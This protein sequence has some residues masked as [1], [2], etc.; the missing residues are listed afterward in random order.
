L[1][2][3]ALQ[4]IVGINDAKH[5][6]NVQ[7]FDFDGRRYLT[8]QLIEH[9][10]PRP[11]AL[12]VHS[13]SGFRDAVNTLLKDPAPYLIHIIDYSQVVLA[14][15]E[16]NKWGERH[17]HIRATL[18]PNIRRFPFG[19]YQD[20]ENFVIALHSHIMN[21]GDFAYVLK[22]ASSITNEAVTTSNDDGITQEIGMKRGVVIQ[23]KENLRPRV[24]LAPWRTFNEV[25]Q[26]E[27]T[28]LLRAKQDGPQTLPR[29]ALFEA[30]GGKWQLEAV[31]NIRRFLAAGIGA[32]L[33]IIA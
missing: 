28:F 18:P 5:D 32:D 4:Y 19:Q 11:E 8:K 1:I 13:L 14:T 20:P 23:G 15:R 10:D 2:T 33:E 24:T 30:D 17:V 21:S 7:K 12:E 22:V 29:L 9:R 16:V 3:E 26:P 6:L 27:S 25:E 31:E